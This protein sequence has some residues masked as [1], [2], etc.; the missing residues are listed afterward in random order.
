ML[1]EKG[2]RVTR[3]K[4]EAEPNSVLVEYEEGPLILYVFNR[5]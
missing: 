1:A 5:V 2:I 4:K 3:G